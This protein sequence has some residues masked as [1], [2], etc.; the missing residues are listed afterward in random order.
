VAGK[1]QYSIFEIKVRIIF[2]LGKWK[3]GLSPLKG[4]IVHNTFPDFD[5]TTKKNDSQLVEF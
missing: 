5:K 2:A 4:R 3:C 1:L